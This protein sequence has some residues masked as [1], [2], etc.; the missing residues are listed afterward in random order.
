MYRGQS[1]QLD[2]EQQLSAWLGKD[3]AGREYVIEQNVN[4]NL[5]IRTRDWK[6]IAP[7]KGSSKYTSANIELGNSQEPQLYRLS[8]D[9]GEQVNR[10]SEYPQV[11]QNLQLRLEQV[12]LK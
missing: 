5:S 9:E 8:D 7:G 2:S 3:K 4:N 12:K 1:S 11:L 10:A 6:Y